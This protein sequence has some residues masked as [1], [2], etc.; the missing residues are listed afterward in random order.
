MAPAPAVELTRQVDLYIK[1]YP[2]RYETGL[3]RAHASVR[4]R[5]ISQATLPMSEV[6]ST[7]ALPIPGAR[8]AS[9]RTTS[10]VPC[11]RGPRNREIP[12]VIKW[13]LEKNC[14]FLH[15]RIRRLHY[16][17]TPQRCRTPSFG[18]KRWLHQS[19][20]KIHE[21]WRT[22]SITRICKETREST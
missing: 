17:K 19:A 20:S 6:I 10:R 22:S 1:V 7:G 5:L 9:K 3:S 15:Y 12:P 11:P 4:S 13:R 14:P 21:H 2:S 8:K 16:K 18:E